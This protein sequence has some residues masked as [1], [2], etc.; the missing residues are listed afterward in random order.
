MNASA[1]IKL[2]PSSLKTKLLDKVVE[3]IAEQAEKWDPNIAKHVRKL[4][5]K[6]AFKESCENAIERAANRFVNEYI[7]QDE[8]IVKALQDDM[9]F[10]KSQSVQTALLAMV[11]QPGAYAIEE[12][13]I[14][15]QEFEDILPERINRD[16][17]NKAI[18]YFL[19]C[20]AEELW[21]LPGA[22][23]IRDI[24]SLQFQHISAEAA[25]EQ[26]ALSR[27]QLQAMAML[28]EEVQRALVQFTEVAEQHFLTSGTISGELPPPRP[29]QNLISRNYIK[30]VGRKAEV[31]KLLRFLSADYG[32]NIITVD[33]IGGVGKTSLVLEVAYRCLEASR[34]NAIEVDAGMPTF[35]A[36]IFTS[37]KQDALTAGGILPR[38]QAQ[39]T[40]QDIFQEISRTLD[41]P[42]ILRAS[43]DEQFQVVRDDLSRQRTLLI[44][45]NL[46]TIEDKQGILS[47]LYELPANVK[48]VITTRER[49]S[50]T[51]IRLTE[52]PEEQGLQLIAQRIHQMS[53]VLS[54]EQCKALYKTTGGIPAA[55]I[56]A[57]G[58]ISSGY[59]FTTVIDRIDDASGD[60]A[61]FCFKSSV[62][63]LEGKPSYYLLLAISMFSKS[64]IRDALKEVANYTDP[65]TVEEGLVQLQ[66]LSLVSQIDSRYHLLPLTREY[67]LAELASHHDFGTEARERWVTW[68]KK[69]VQKYGGRTSSKQE[70]HIDFD[71]IEEEW[72]NIQEVLFWCM[73][74]EY[75]SEVKELWDNVRTFTN[76]HGYWHIRLKC[77]D[78]L[79]SAAERRGDLSTAMERFS[80]KGRV[81][82]K[83]G[84]MDE[85]LSI[86]DKAWSLREHS[87][88][89][90]RLSILAGRLSEAFLLQGNY[91][92]ALEWLKQAGSVI[93]KQLPEKA[94]KRE[95][96]F[97]KY[98]KALIYYKMKDY[99]KAEEYLHAIIEETLVVER[100]RFS[101]Y[102]QELLIEVKIG[103]GKLDKVKNLAETGLENAMRNK[104]KRLVAYYKR[105][106][107]LIAKESGN[108]DETERWASEAFDEFERL[109]AIHE[110]KEVR[111]L[112]DMN[113]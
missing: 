48:V 78:W 12:H 55:I 4:S 10:W 3:V 92:E 6:V 47:F 101:M 85:A 1:V 68:Y 18:V 50:I 13:T 66:R 63:I 54:E 52:L 5:S 40:L 91:D 103:L 105:A 73:D 41:R 35:D 94:K 46:E 112:M 30:F 7:Q 100:Q 31:D 67:A 104:D 58:Q 24:Y 99:A 71:R 95:E 36:I 28:G 8:D 38:Q 27:K 17:V 84:R 80:E 26:V 19:R 108:F 96:Y 70:W 32:L 113:K 110:A 43:P 106:L 29:Y 61:R 25:R 15:T 65:I 56:Y 39:R 9:N 42:D 57:I 16:R 93:E 49:Q 60:V 107:A 87:E 102:V 20:I 22:K 83:M 53:V 75:Y 72:P 76:V 69:F 111:A 77:S 33:G 82:H 59:S 86:L 74:E 37:A 11:K 2:I 64:P 23:E 89:P 97:I 109:G 34:T 14:I 44:V 45:D 51:P 21:T 62:E 98:R 88:Y 81:L 90:I 79:A